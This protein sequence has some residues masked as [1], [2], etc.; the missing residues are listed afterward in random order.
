MTFQRDSWACEASEGSEAV[1]DADLAIVNHP[2]NVEKRVPEPWC[3]QVELNWHTERDHD[4]ELRWFL[5]SNSKL[6]QRD[7]FLCFLIL[8]SMLTCSPINLQPRS[9]TRH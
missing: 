7:R 9:Y 6:L 3:W 1:R 8:K 2:A 5:L 4:V